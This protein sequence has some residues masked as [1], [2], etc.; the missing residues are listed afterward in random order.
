MNHEF[1][2]RQV[3]RGVGVATLR[4]LRRMVDAENAQNAVEARWARRLTG[5]FLFLAAAF[6]AGLTLMR[7]RG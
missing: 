6:V 5:L 2:E 3:R 4:R 1:V 7:M